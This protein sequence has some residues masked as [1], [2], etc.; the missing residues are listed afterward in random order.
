MQSQ[1]VTAISKREKKVKKGV[2]HIGDPCN[3]DSMIKVANST[4]GWT[5]SKVRYVVIVNGTEYGFSTLAA[6]RYFAA[7]RNTVPVRVNR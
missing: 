6:P 2:D 7:E 3:T 1:A 5:M 4:E